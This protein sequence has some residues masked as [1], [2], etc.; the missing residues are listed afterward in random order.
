M[1]IYTKSYDT[2]QPC[3]QSYL[4]TKTT[5]GKEENWSLFTGGLYS[6]GQ[7]YIDYANWR[8]QGLFTAF[9]QIISEIIKLPKAIFC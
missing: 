4:S 9:N 6:E 3:I 5:H 7:F 1:Q 2:E 8:S